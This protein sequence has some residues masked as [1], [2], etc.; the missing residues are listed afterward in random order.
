MQ[1]QIILLLSLVICCF[2]AYSQECTNDGE[3]EACRALA[4]LGGPT[5]F[6]ESS[7]GMRLAVRRWTPPND[8]PI[9]SSLIVQHGGAGWHSGYF[10]GLGQALSAQGIAVIAYDQM[11]S[12]YSDSFKEGLRYY[13]DSMDT[14][15]NDLEKIVIRV[16]NDYPGKKVF[17]L[18]ESLGGLQVLYHILRDS[19]QENTTNRF[20]ADGYILSAPVIN[21]KKGILPPKPI[22]RFMQWL[23]RF[24]PMAKMPVAPGFGPDFDSAF[25]DPRWARAGRMDP[26]VQ[27]AANTPPRL[28]MLRSMF[29]AISKVS[30]NLDQ[31]AVPF[32]ILIGS[33]ET[34]VDV[35]DSERLYEVAHSK[36]KAFT[37]V[38]GGHHQLYQDMPQVT[39]FVIDKVASWILERS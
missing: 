32:H 4:P 25:G 36:D 6:I 38:E 2:K 7:L 39:Q 26:L 31:V 37:R 19:S 28:G 15:A 23:G 33:K 1:T 14:V 12:G 13:F 5:E 16:K 34:R 17:V 22:V 3:D 10:D 8:D 21:I 29:L 20:L 35:S 30:D 24:F 18:G 27:E 9:K 11:G